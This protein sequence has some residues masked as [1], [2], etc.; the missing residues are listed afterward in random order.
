MK[1]KIVELEDLYSNQQKLTA[2][3]GEKLAM[4]KVKEQLRGGI[5]PNGRNQEK[6]V[7]YFLLLMADRTQEN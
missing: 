2:D 3:L 4:A 1:Q 5:S 6:K 7:S